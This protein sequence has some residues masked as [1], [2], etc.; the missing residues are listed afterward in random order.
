VAPKK[1]GAGIACADQLTARRLDQMLVIGR[2]LFAAHLA[3][4]DR[5]PFADKTAQGRERPFIW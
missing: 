4:F 5:D 2:K 3:L 1:H